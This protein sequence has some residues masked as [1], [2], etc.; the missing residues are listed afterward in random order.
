MVTH[1]HEPA[2][3]TASSG[4]SARPLAHLWIKCP[5]CGALLY[6]RQL[7]RNLKVCPHC[8]YHFRLGARERL[9]QLLDPDSFAERDPDMRATDPLGFSDSRAY[10]ERVDEAR[11]RTGLADACVYGTGTLDGSPCVAAAMDFGF[12]GGSMGS[13]VGE[14]ITR[15]AE[16][17][18]ARRAPLVVVSTSGG[19]RMQEGAISLMQMAKVSAALQ[20]LS[21][22]GIPFFSVLADPTYGGVTASYATLGDVVLAEPRAMIG[23]AGPSVI[24][25]TIRETLPEGFQRAEFL[26]EH[27]FVDILA[28]RATLRETLARLL[29]LHAEQGPL[30]GAAG[31][32]LGAT[33]VVRSAWETVELARHRERPRARQYVD[34]AFAGFVELHGDRGF[35]DDPAVVGGLARLGERTVVVIATQK[36]HNARENRLRNFGMPNPE[37]YRKALRLMRYADR[38]GFPVVTLIDTPGAYPGIG[39]EERGQAE[40]IARNLLEMAAL[41]VPVIAVVIS[42]GGSGGALALGVANRVLMMEHAIYSVISPEGCAV[43]LWKDARAAPRAAEALRLTAVA[44]RELGVVDEIVP[45][46][47]AGAH[48]EPAA[49][50]AACRAA[51]LRHLQALLELDPAAL[52]EQRYQRFRQFGAS[53]AA[54]EPRASSAPATTR[55]SQP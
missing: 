6:H 11:Q 39:A 28:P 32:S 49:A 1:A 3:A 9:A 50:I 43:I 16:L 20:R 44:L 41:R 36:G 26:L 30:S 5:N 45:E 38:F 14:K 35:R 47:G 27:G 21:A 13:V 31:G 54:V 15:A 37:G 12:M 55:R 2:R 51:V 29:A 46:P 34:Q 19:A 48:A 4:Q 7:A 10:P 25:Q 52:V 23:F 40:A 33:Q 8:Q 42:E 18:L 53:R 17:A 24:E 22:H